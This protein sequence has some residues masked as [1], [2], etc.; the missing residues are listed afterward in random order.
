MIP[1]QDLHKN[2]Q[3]KDYVHLEISQNNYDVKLKALY[4]VL[5]SEYFFSLVKIFYKNNYKHLS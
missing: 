3:I 5:R 4:F 1:Y 2:P